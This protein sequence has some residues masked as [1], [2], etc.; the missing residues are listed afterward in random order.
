[1]TE[2][3]R[4]LVA[5]DADERAALRALGG[6]VAR[7]EPLADDLDQSVAIASAAAKFLV[8]RSPEYDD[9]AEAFN[10][11]S[12]YYLEQVVPVDRSN[13]GDATQA[14][15]DLAAAQRYIARLRTTGAGTHGGTP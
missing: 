9:Y 2:N 5:Y 8:N 6:F 1:V 15:A 14:Y 7:L 10:V 13:G 11:V 4:K 12:D 3:E